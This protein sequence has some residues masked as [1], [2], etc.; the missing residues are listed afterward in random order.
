MNKPGIGKRH[1]NK[2]RILLLPDMIYQQS[3]LSVH[4]IEPSFPGTVPGF[5]IETAVLTVFPENLRLPD[6]VRNSVVMHE[7]FG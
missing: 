6:S 1:F 5:K 2:Y 7:S 4:Y 3:F